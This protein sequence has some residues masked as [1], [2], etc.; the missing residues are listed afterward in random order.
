MIPSIIHYCWFGDN[1]IPEESQ[2]LIAEWKTLH[3]GW[4]FIQWNESN[5]PMEIPYLSRALSENRF[6]NLSNLVRLHALR[7]M[8]GFYLDTDFKIL[9]PLDALRHNRCFFGFE[10]GMEDS[11]LFWVNNAICGAEPGHPF[12]NQVYNALLE[13]FDGTEDA[14]LSSPRLIT[15]QLQQAKN[16]TKYGFQ[17]LDDVTLYPKE[18]FYPI[19]YNEAYKLAEVEKHIFSETIAIHLWSRSWLNHRSLLAIIDDLNRVN[20]S[21]QKRIDQLED[22]QQPATSVALLEKMMDQMLEKDRVYQSLRQDWLQLFNDQKM[23]QA[24]QYDLHKK[25]ILLEKDLENQVA[26]NLRIQSELEKQTLAN[27]QLQYSL[28]QINRELADQKAEHTKILSQRELIQ[29]E[30]GETRFLRDLE[31]KQTEEQDFQM[32]EY[33][34]STEI[35]RTLYRQLQQELL[36]LKSHQQSYFETSDRLKEEVASL[37]KSV[38]WYQATFEK[39]ALAGIAKDRVLKKIHSLGIKVSAPG[40]SHKLKKAAKPSSFTNRILCSIVNHNCNDNTAALRK[41]LSVYFDTIVF[42]SASDKKEPYFVSLGNVYYSGLLNHSYQCAKEKG[43]DYLLL[44]C[45]DVHFEMAEIEKM[46]ASLH[47]NKLEGI[48]IYSPCSTGRSHVFCKREFDRGLRAVPFTEG[49]IFLSSLKVLDEFLPVNL[50]TNLYGWGLDV[51]KG[52]YSRKQDLLCVIDD[53][54][55]VYHPESTGYSNEK[56]E[57]DMWNWVNLIGD[58]AFKRFFTTHINIIRNG[59]A[60]RYKVSVIIPC[61]NQSA[62]LEST[63][64][65]VLLQEYPHVEILAINDGSTD[66]TEEVA[67]AIATRFPQVKYFHKTNAGLGNTRNYGIEKSKGDLIQFLDADDL[68]STDKLLAQVYSMMQ[69]DRIDVSYTPYL[70][71]EDGNHSN[72]WTYSRVELKGDPLEDLIRNWELELSIPVHCFL[73][74]KQVLGD[75]RFDEE[76]PNHE[77]WLFHIYV[78]ASRPEYSF[79]PGGLA[80]Y[81]VR[82]NSMARD[83]SA[84][85]KGKTMCLQKAI[86][87]GRIHAKHLE[88]LQERLEPVASV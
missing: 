81:R 42:D 58:I 82:T 19:H 45:S 43:Y 5:S 73:F 31:K 29:H 74:K 56:A 67:K 65:S 48:G 50:N 4:T 44:I 53:G 20:Q 72:T 26:A 62:Y 79:L 10:E 39:R 71:F 51:A 11:S 33:K 3:P 21:L 35:F 83:Q 63:I 13:Q 24:A 9:K 88:W 80:L 52:Y 14:N 49:F 59:W 61:F 25:A 1:P 55:Q 34:A 27:D 37:W 47:E 28:R 87:S 16:L 41:N 84:M 8:G 40:V 15:Q 17:Q 7:E 77:D 69:E 38:Q 86:H 46:V 64:R 66:E 60:N 6:A 57:K 23:L 2:A 85:K 76:L 36:D 68:L 32:E 12:I 22:K 18:Y 70:C 75:I 30:L 54:V 78:A